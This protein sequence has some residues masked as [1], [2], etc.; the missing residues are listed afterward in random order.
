[1]TNDYFDNLIWKKGKIGKTPSLRQDNND[2]M[3]K[4]FSFKSY[5]Y[6]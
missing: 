3:N 2:Q 5:I 1:M 6:Q 4:K